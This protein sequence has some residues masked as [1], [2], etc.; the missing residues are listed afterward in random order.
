[1][2]EHFNPIAAM[3]RLEKAG[4][5]RKHAEALADEL[6]GATVQL[7]TQ[8]Q[9]QAALDRQTIRICGIL[10]A[11]MALGFTGLGV[12]ISLSQ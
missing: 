4:L 1:M 6:R 10:G 9:L 7:V 11:F 5:T 3:Q 12:L 2:A 8:E